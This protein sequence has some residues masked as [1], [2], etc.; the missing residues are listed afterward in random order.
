MM[1]SLVVVEMFKE[2]IMST[3]T[4]TL[5]MIWELTSS[6]RTTATFRVFSLLITDTTACCEQAKSGFGSML[7][8]F[9]R[10]IRVVLLES[11]MRK[12]CFLLKKL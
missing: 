1:I 9:T 11:E 6:A 2:S 5:N 3:I 8:S 7:V 12:I 4:S 10:S